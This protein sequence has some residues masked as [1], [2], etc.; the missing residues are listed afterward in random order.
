MGL[1]GVELIMD[2]EEAFG[3]ELTDGEAIESV[4]P[5][6]MGDAI[7]SKL[8]ATDERTCQSQRAFYILRRAL[9]KMF[10]VDRKSIKPDTRFRDFIEKSR[11]KE[12]WEQMRLAVAARSWPKL[13]LP[14]TVSRFLTAATLAILSMMV[15]AAI[16][17]SELGCV[18]GIILLV[19][20]L[21][22]SNELAPPYRNYIPPRFKTV[23]D[24]VPYAITSDQIKWTREQVSVL[25][26]QI[27]T[28]ALGVKESEYTE[29]SR[30]VEDLGMNS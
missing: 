7:F 5:R 22:I 27:V 19:V 3:I 29:D 18:G 20:F 1:Q 13:T 8:K 21:R 4:T 15:Y 17:S 24:L 6:M 23:R 26:K 30:F 2:F 28:E 9:V 12:I 25:V 10:N 16:C 14:L 11:E